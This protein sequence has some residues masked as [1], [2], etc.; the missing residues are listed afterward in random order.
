VSI[1]PSLLTPSKDNI[2]LVILAG[3]QGRRVG[4]QQKALIEYQ[5]KA[6][7]SSIIDAVNDQASRLYININ[8]P[9]SDYSDYP[10]PLFSD[11]HLGFLGPLSGM[12]SAW[13][14]VSTDWV[15][16]IP[17][18]NP[19]VSSELVSYLI[20]A[21]QQQPAPLVVAFDGERI[22]PLYLLMHRSQAPKLLN[23]IEQSHLSVH[24]WIKSQV[25][26][27]AD[28]SVLGK[29]VFKNLNTLVQFT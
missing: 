2:S 7:L 26:T 8:A 11:L 21:Y 10:Y 27:C 14:T 15:V 9:E 17:C 18:D 5:G 20:S 29:Q 25:Y 13:S 6:V 16:F 12:Q 19:W 4:Y 23:A 22:Q 24:R 3:G 1:K 28:C